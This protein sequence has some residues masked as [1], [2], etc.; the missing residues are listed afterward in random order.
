M[1]T[2]KIMMSSEI[3]SLIFVESYYL[4]VVLGCNVCKIIYYTLIWTLYAAHSL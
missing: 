3:L 2:G 1:Y 4:E